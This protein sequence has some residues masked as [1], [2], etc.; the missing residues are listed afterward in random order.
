MDPNKCRPGGRAL[1]FWCRGQTMALQDIAD[2]L[3]ANLVPQIGQC[4]DDPVITPVMV[5][6]GHA[7][8]QLLESSLD[9]ASARGPARIRTI[10]FADDQLAVP[11]Q[12]GVR[13]GHSCYLADDH[14]AQSKTN[15][16]ELGTLGVREPVHGEFVNL[17]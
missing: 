8:D 12:D 4:S 2:R 3:I 11:C 5:L 6:L 17:A 14:A 1:A 16:P 9:P 15:L 7:N 10:E 13:P